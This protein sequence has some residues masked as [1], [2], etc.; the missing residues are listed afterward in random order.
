MFELPQ[1]SV[2]TQVR[3]IVNSWGHA[4]PTVTSLEVITGFG[5]QSVAVA[6]PVAAG[7]VLSVHCTVRSAGQ[8]IAGGV[9]SL[10]NIVCTQELKLPQSSVA[11][12]VRVI[13]PS[14]GQVPTANESEKLMVDTGSQLSVAVAV[15]VITGNVPEVHSIVTL[16]G[17]VI[18]GGRLSSTC[19]I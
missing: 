7:A 19:I 14:C 17:Q 1:A 12:H 16:L 4:P 15:P 18:T 2:A 8:V 3:V 11:V 6:E 10:T 5:S 9:L 13:V